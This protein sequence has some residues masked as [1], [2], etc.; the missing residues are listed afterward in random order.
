[1]LIRTCQKHFD[2]NSK[3][4]D[5]ITPSTYLGLVGG[6]SIDHQRGQGC[7]LAD[8]LEDLM[9]LQ[10]HTKISVRCFSTVRSIVVIDTLVNDTPLGPIKHHD[11][12]GLVSKS[13]QMAL[14]NMTQ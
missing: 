14:L 9:H 6:T 2:R 10:K 7:S 12:C 1:M 8:F 13:V 11:V 3:A 4:S 5:C